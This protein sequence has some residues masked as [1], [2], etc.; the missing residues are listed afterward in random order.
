MGYG[1]NVAFVVDGGPKIVTVIV[2][3]ILNDGGPVRDYGWGRL[4][5]ATDGVNGLRPFLPG[6]PLGN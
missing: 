4:H 3:G 1:Q 5:Q 2:D 6:R